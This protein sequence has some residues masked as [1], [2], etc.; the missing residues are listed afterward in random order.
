MCTFFVV[1]SADTT[2]GRVNDEGDRTWKLSGGNRDGDG[3]GSTQ[4][5]W[6]AG[7]L[8]TTAGAAGSTEEDASLISEALQELQDFEAAFIKLGDL[9]ENYKLQSFENI[10]QFGHRYFDE[11]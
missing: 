7:H 2:G 8:K 6:S 11:L 1:E 4:F 9:A 3:T 10:L 5:H